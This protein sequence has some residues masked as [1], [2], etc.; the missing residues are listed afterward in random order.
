MFASILLNRLWRRASNK[1]MEI[2][3][4]YI[5][6]AI[7]GSIEFCG[8]F[9][10]I[11]ILHDSKAIQSKEGSK[12]IMPDQLVT[13]VN[14]KRIDELERLFRATGPRPNRTRYGGSSKK[15]NAILN[16]G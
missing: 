16:E 11:T 3:A 2:L 5:V 10:M 13:F 12:L 4:A 1:Q 6:F 8:K 15:R 7:K 9:T 14:W